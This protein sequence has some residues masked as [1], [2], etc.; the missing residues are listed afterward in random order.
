M[1]QEDD[2]DEEEEEVG[3]CQS[4]EEELVDYAPQAFSHFTYCATGGR[5]L[6]CD[7]QVGPLSHISIHH[8]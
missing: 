7:L 8:F 2:E 3:G 6:V 5:E 1:I 4:E